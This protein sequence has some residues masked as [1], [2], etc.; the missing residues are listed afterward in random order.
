L[1]YV[2]Y[3]TL[4]LKYYGDDAQNILVY[5][6]INRPPY[7]WESK[8]FAT[9]CDVKT[10]DTILINGTLLSEGMFG[11]SLILKAYDYSYSLLSDTEI[12]TIYTCLEPI[13]VGQRY[14]DYEVMDFTR[15]EGTTYHHYSKFALHTED[16]LDHI[17]R[18]INRDPRRG[19]GWWHD[20]WVWWCGYTYYRDL[21][22]DDSHLDPQF[23]A[24]VFCE[25]RAAVMNLMEVIKNCLDVEGVVDLTFNHTGTKKVDVE[26]YT[27]SN[28]FF[29]GWWTWF[30]G[31]YDLMPGDTFFVDGSSLTGGVLTDRIMMRVYDASTG[32]LLDTIYI[33]SSGEWFM[34][35]EPGNFYGDFEILASTLLLGDDS[36]WDDW[37]GG[38]S[39]WWD[40]FFGF[41]HWEEQGAS[42][43]G[44]EPEECYDAEAAKEEQARICG[45]VTLL[46]QV[47]N[48][49]VKADDILARIAWA[50]AENTTV[51]NAS[52]AD[53]YKYHVEWAKRYWYR[54]YDRMRK[55]RAYDAITDFKNSWR[56]SMLSM[57][58]ALKTTDDPMPDDAVA[59]PCGCFDLSNSEYDFSYPW[60]MHWYIKY[61][62][63]GHLKKCE[64]PEFPCGGG[65]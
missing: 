53:E 29:G 25:E 60:W 10:N 3:D 61:S 59:D 15:L 20:V 19:Y 57:K 52:Y 26:V 35:V 31:F 37:W 39:M 17:L 6:Q 11:T 41:W 22:V 63:W 4:K 1:D 50:E 28:W 7:Y 27:L 45:N 40:W 21:W 30:D 33:R 46:K 24:A 48:M 64:N 32:K 18:S 55:G 62:N 2:G 58:W 23:G 51:K 65:C 8:L 12:A 9:L 13:K 16:A 49:L 43:C 44:W 34:E 14:G 36:E 47:I 38:D 42:R 5:N 56:H 54:G